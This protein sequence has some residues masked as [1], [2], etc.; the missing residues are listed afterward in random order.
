MTEIKSLISKIDEQNSNKICKDIAKILMNKYQLNINNNKF[1]ISE[2]EFYIYSDK[3]PD[4]YV[5]K[6]ELQKEF[7]KFYVHPKDGNYGG[8]DFV[9]GD[10]QHNIF[11]GVLIRGLKSENNK[12]FTGP[13]ILK[14]EIY[15]LLNVTNH[16]ELQKIVDLKMK[17]VPYDKEKEILHSTRIGLKPKF[18]DYLN[19]GKYIY[20]LHRFITDTDNK[21]HKYQEKK[22]VKLYNQDNK[23]EEP[24]SNPHA[25]Y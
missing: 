23:T 2:I 17:I 12:F 6:H 15:R 16:A 4:P 5:H 21:Q 3:H 18:E 10:T 20:K 24:I 7:G 19:D 9:L 13:N 25:G 22:N 14:K 11:C 8:I 1:N